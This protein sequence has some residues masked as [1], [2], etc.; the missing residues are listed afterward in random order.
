MVYINNYKCKYYNENKC[1]K[2]FY[3]KNFFIFQKFLHKS[4]IN[5]SIINFLII[6]I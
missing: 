6:I 1:T 4:E 5:I 3:Y 2:K